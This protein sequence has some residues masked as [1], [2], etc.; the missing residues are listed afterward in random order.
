MSDNKQNQ[1]HIA[2]CDDDNIAIEQVKGFIT[3]VCE[4]MSILHVV[5]TYLDGESLIK[6]LS[7]GVCYDL[8]FLDIEMSRLSGVQV[9]AAI[10]DVYQDELTQIVYISAKSEYA[11]ELFDSNPLNFLVKPIS[12]NDIEK[13]IE[14]FAKVTGNWSDVFTYKYGHDTYKMK[15]KDII[16]LESS[17]KKIIIHAKSKNDEYYGSI[18][19]AYESQLKRY[20]F[21]FIHRAYVVNYDHVT[22]FEY[23]QLTLSDKT[24][25]PIGQARRKE[26][27]NRQQELEKRRDRNG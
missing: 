11:I 1:Y 3:S 19:E 18:E 7:S 5:D 24:T 21:L 22:A 10:R 26:I 23:E 2:I 14:K 9:G 15:L 12:Y 4:K 27:R 8:I 6:E 13:V 20:G 25:L 17:G 16:Y